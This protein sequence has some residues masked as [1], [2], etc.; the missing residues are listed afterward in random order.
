MS[1]TIEDVNAAE[2]GNSPI[3]RRGYAKGE[4]DEFLGRIAQTL[5][6]KDDLTAAEVH[7]VLFN[8][9]IIGKRGYD[10]REVDEFLDKAEEELAS[11]TGVRAQPVPDARDESEAAQPWPVDTPTARVEHFQEK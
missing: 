5:A 3:G 1:L 6:G 11:R 9:P 4:V 8:R 10:E 2:F 7:H